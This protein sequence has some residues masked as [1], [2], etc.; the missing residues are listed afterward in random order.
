MLEDLTK[1][2]IHI[3][4]YD[5]K[6]YKHYEDIDEARWQ[7]IKTGAQ[8]MSDHRISPPLLAIQET[9]DTKTLIYSQ[10]ILM[11]YS[12][13]IFPDLNSNEVVRQ[14]NG[15]VQ[16]MHQLGYGHGDLHNENILFGSVN[17][18]TPR[19]Y[20]IDFDTIYPIKVTSTVSDDN[21]GYYDYVEL[22]IE[23]WLEKWIERKT[24]GGIGHDGFVNADYYDWLDL[25]D[26]FF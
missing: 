19:F 13:E 2:P 9:P 18:G 17:D 3:E 4:F 24:G 14:I 26:S 11:K 6:F 25:L 21:G 10:V 23:P 22:E 1:I 7:R 15:L 5:G 12:S 16:R 8:T 20:L